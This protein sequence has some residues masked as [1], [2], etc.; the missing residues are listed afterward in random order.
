MQLII[1]S[2]DEKVFQVIVEFIR[3]FNLTFRQVKDANTVSPEERRRRIA[4]V[5]KFRGGLKQRFNGYQPSK[6]EWYEQ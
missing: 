4:V 1:E 3:P 6:N 5:R 2:T